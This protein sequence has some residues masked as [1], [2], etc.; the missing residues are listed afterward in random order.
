MRTCFALD[1][2]QL[3]EIQW[4]LESEFDVHALRKSLSVMQCWQLYTEHIEKL[5]QAEVDLVQ[6]VDRDAKSSQAERRQLSSTVQKAACALAE[7]VA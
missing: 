5:R 2:P 6:Q 1:S 4:K 7:T 3:A